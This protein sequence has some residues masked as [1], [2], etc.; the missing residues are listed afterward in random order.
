VRSS[1]GTRI[2]FPVSVQTI[3]IPH[4]KQRRKRVEVAAS[5]LGNFAL[6]A[7]ARLPRHERVAYHIGTTNEP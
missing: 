7:H 1:S 3:L 2:A 6:H 4:Y 5:K